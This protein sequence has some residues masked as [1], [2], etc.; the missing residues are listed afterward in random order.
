MVSRKT[1]T[2]EETKTN[3]RSPA[4]VVSEKATTR[5]NA[6][7][8]KR[9]TGKQMLMAGVESGEFDE[10]NNLAFQFTSNT[11]FTPLPLISTLHSR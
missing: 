9:Q 8:T 11:T 4:T 7:K 3:R 1:T 5:L 6:I 2:R 10:D